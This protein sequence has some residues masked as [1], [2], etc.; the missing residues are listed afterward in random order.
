MFQGQIGE[1]P[2]LS[3][4]KSGL[5]LILALFFHP[6]LPKIGHSHPVKNYFLNKY[7]TGLH[8]LIK[9]RL[10]K[11]K[12]T[13]SIRNCIKT[14]QLRFLQ[15]AMKSTWQLNGYHGDKTKDIDKLYLS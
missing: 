10:D 1:I 4:G 3:P 11:S 5:F 2:L 14:F 9:F 6:S 15:K 8:P 13:V 12:I 7:G